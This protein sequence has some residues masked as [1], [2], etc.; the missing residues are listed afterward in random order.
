[1]PLYCRLLGELSKIK[2]FSDILNKKRNTV[3]IALG[4]RNEN[5]EKS[6]QNFANVA[7]G[8][9]RNINSLDILKYKYLLITK[10]KESVEFLVGKI[11][12]SKNQ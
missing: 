1:M 5:T 11:D 8:E 2:G 9:V 3:C 12:N 7:L 4:E 6:F 10:P